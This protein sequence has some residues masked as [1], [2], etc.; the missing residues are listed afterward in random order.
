MAI[1]DTIKYTVTSEMNLDASTTQALKN[2]LPKLS[3]TISTY[4]D[5]GSMPKEYI[6][7]TIIPELTKL[8]TST[9]A[10]LIDTLNTNKS[11]FHDLAKEV[12]TSIQKR[13]ETLT[14]TPRKWERAQPLRTTMSGVVGTT[15]LNVEYFLKSVAW[16]QDD[17][18][19]EE[20]LLLEVY[21]RA[22]R[23]QEK[24]DNYVYE[25]DSKQYGKWGWPIQNRI[26]GDDVVEFH[27]TEGKENARAEVEDTD[28]DKIEDI[29]KMLTDNA[30][31]PKS[32]S[33]NF[34]PMWG[35]NVSLGSKLNQLAEMASYLDALERGLDDTHHWLMAQWIGYVG[36]GGLWLAK[37]FLPSSIE[38]YAYLLTWGTLL[39]VAWKNWRW[40]VPANWAKWMVWGG[41][42]PAGTTPWATTEWAPESTNKTVTI[43]GKEYYNPKSDSYKELETAIKDAIEKAKIAQPAVG[44]AGNPGYKPATI[45]ISE[46]EANIRT[47]KALRLLEEYK[48]DFINGKSMPDKTN[49][50]LKLSKITDGK[51]V[52]ADPTKTWLARWLSTLK[53]AVI[54]PIIATKEAVVLTKEGLSG[55]GWS[56]NARMAAIKSAEDLTAGNK[57]E[58]FKVGTDTYTFKW[59]HAEVA[60]NMKA[61]K[62]LFTAREAA[63]KWEIAETELSKHKGN[64]TSIEWQIAKLQAS[65]WWKK[66]T[67]NQSQTVANGATSHNAS[68][69]EDLTS[70]AEKLTEKLTLA[71]ENVTRYSA[72]VDQY[73]AQL[74]TYG[75][76]ANSAAEFTDIESKINTAITTA[77]WSKRAYIYDIATE[78]YIASPEFSYSRALGFFAKFFKK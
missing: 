14:F 3:D 47:V 69:S 55:K 44:T 38:W 70:S 74:S 26:S 24:F 61:M 16:L 6:E 23:V 15:L 71:N 4:S 45:A 20:T 77:E 72:L 1:Y 56:L 42:I 43:K 33:V 53:T 39:F 66:T 49:F 51:T 57:N 41:A 76:P 10:V 37:S 27:W 8:D 18:E 62:E 5:N 67:A 2:A 19:R 52:I 54:R 32:V 35:E 7:S 48:Q 40:K 46:K 9:R 58:P 63:E 30:K 25:G 17:K 50:E 22:K 75:T 29:L 11:S 65:G 64:V 59:D 21:S 78:K 31:D 13:Q 28:K 73:K 68:Q 12:H 60:K 34:V 36:Q